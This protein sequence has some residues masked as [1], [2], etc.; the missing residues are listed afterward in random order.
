[1][2]T[3]SNKPQIEHEIQVMAQFISH[4]RGNEIPAPLLVA[5]ADKALETLKR[6]HGGYLR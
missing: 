2:T 6:L 5:E 1:M 4:A 3:S